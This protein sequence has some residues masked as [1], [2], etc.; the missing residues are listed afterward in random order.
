[1]S[2]ID[3]MLLESEEE[4]ALDKAYD[5]EVKAFRETPTYKEHEEK[6]QEIMDK[7]KAVR[8]A[9][10]EKAKE[11]RHEERAHKP[12][13]VKKV[14]KAAKTKRREKASAEV[15]ELIN[16]YNSLN[17]QDKYYFNLMTHVSINELPKH[18]NPKTTQQDIY[19]L[20]EVLVQDVIEFINDRGL[21]DIDAVHF[22]ADGLTVSAKEGEWTPSTDS[23]ITVEGLDTTD[24]ICPSRTFIGYSA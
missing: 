1:M 8:K 7:M 20:Q 4:K 23:S 18:V 10:I 13:D 11:T 3:I 21:E 17:E 9:R 16:K 22:G 2:W 15:Q 14:I 24:E 12:V 19:D 6:V 5:D